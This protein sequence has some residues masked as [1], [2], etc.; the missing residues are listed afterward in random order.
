MKV[1]EYILVTGVAVSIGV[2]V[3]DKASTTR[4]TPVPFDSSVNV[5]GLEKPLEDLMAVHED[6]VKRSESLSD[7][8]VFERRIFK[9]F[10]DPAAKKPVV[11]LKKETDHEVQ[12]ICEGII[13]LG[14]M[15]KVIIGGD[16]VGVGDKLPGGY[17][18]SSI[19]ADKVM[20]ELEGRTYTIPLNLT[21]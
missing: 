1:S 20:L 18:I 10:T 5:K 19:D 14:N 9:K 12:L 2:F 21:E 7:W 8:T 11:E 3:Y 16:Y 4:E 6:V 17:T 15:K 13:V